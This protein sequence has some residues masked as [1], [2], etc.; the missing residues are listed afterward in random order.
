MVSDGLSTVIVKSHV[1]VLQPSVAVTWMWFVVPRANTVPD[2]GVEVM[3]MLV[4]QLSVTIMD[5]VTN[6]FV[7]HVATNLFVQKSVGGVVS[8]T[9]TRCVHVRLWFP[10][11]SVALQMRDTM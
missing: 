7:P 1:L 6:A 11:Q 4:V 2:G 5:H 8:T 3:I 9:V 10:Q